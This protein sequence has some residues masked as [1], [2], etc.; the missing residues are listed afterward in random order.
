L[1]GWVF[2]IA[3]SIF[4]G[5]VGRTG[6]NLTLVALKLCTFKVYKKLIF[7]RYT[8]NSFFDFFSDKPDF[9]RMP[10]NL[11]GKISFFAV[12]KN[13]F[14]HPSFFP[15]IKNVFSTN[16]QKPANHDFRSDKNFILNFICVQHFLILFNFHCQNN[17]YF[18]FLFQ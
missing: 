1:Q 16:R 14:H 11:C 2:A 12:Q 7:V 6:K 4:A 13:Y 5:T 9:D 3:K 8:K 10:H 15:Q 17:F 18:S